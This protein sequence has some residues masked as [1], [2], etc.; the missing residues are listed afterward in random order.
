MFPSPT[1]LRATTGLEASLALLSPAMFMAY[2]LNWYS[3]PSIR[4]DTL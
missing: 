2:T 4:L 3:R 1:G